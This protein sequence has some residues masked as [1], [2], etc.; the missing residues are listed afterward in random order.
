MN[1]KK[2]LEFIKKMDELRNQEKQIENEFIK[3]FDFKTYEQEEDARDWFVD[4]V[5]NNDFETPEERAS[6]LIEKIKDILED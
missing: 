4:I 3:A 2:T 5:I 6:M 1:E